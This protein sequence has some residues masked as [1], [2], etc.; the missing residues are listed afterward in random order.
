MIRSA[1]ELRGAHFL[2]ACDLSK[3]DTVLMIPG[4]N[5]PLNPLPLIMGATMLW[6]AKLT[7]VSPGMDPAQ[8]KI[9]KYMP[10]MMVV[11]LYNFSAGL[12]LY[13]TVQNLLTIAQMKLTKTDDTPAPPAKAP[14]SVA[15]Q[16]KKK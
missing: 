10:L 1:I 3:P 13:W 8:Q 12:A 2:W 4:L 15:P 16:K 14:V 7:P 11:F 9:M 6:Q 5:F